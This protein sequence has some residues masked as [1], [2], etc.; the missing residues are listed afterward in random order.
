MQILMQFNKF[1]VFYMCLLLHVCCYVSV[2][3]HVDT[4]SWHPVSS[5]RSSHWGS[6]VSFGNSLSMFPQM[7]V[8]E[9]FRITRLDSKHFNH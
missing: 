1:R 2:H 6:M 7:R 5:D 9:K 8:I 4:Q 3:I